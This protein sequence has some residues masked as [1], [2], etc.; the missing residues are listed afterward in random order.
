METV[1]IS[2]GTGMIG[3]HLTKTLLAKNYKVIILSRTAGKQATADNLTYAQWDL[4]KQTINKESVEKADYIIHLA[5][6]GVADKRWNKKRK[7]EIVDSRVKSGELFC[8][9]LEQNTNKVKAVISIS[10]IGWYGPDPAIP[11]P[12]PFTEEDPAS[13]DFLADTCKQWEASIAPV[14]KQGKRLVILRTGIVLSKDGGALKEFEKPLKFGVATILGSGR[15]VISW[16]HIEDLTR[17][18]ITAIENENISGVYNAVAANSISNK[19]F[20]MKLGA[21]KRGKFFI[22]IPVPSFAL[23]MVLGEMS[24]EVLKSAT[25]SCAKLHYAGF[26]FL[27]PSVDEALKDL[28]KKCKI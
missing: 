19:E 15:Q 11:N 22:P 8:K 25:V 9:A 26:N 10:G 14:T 2:G 27:Y 3:K 12:D 17:L 5:G 6:A 23:K 20:M 4:D 13:D 24:I 7:Q 16:I 18:F 21:I 1:L 28:T